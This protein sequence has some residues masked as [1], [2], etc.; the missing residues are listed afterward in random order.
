MKLRV[1]KMRNHFQVSNLDD[2]SLREILAKAAMEMLNMLSEKQF[3]MLDRVLGAEVGRDPQLGK[4]F[5][6]IGP[7]ALLQSLSELIQEAADRGEI[8]SQNIEYSAEMFPSLVLGRQ[9]TLMRFGMKLDFS[10]S[11]KSERAQRAVN[12]WMQLHEV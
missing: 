1:D 3:L 11:A 2:H 6:E 10:E 4:Y 9:D 5:L 7:L 8:S 12:A